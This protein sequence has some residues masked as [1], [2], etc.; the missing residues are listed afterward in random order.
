MNNKVLGIQ[1]Q[2][3]DLFVI[4]V[5]F[6]INVIFCWFVDYYFCLTRYSQRISIKQTHPSVGKNHPYLS[7]VLSPEKHIYFRKI[8]FS[9]TT[10]N[11]LTKSVCYLTLLSCPCVYNFLKRQSDFWQVEKQSTPNYWIEWLLGNSAHRTPRSWNMILVILYLLLKFVVPFLNHSWQY[12]VSNYRRLFI[13]ST[14]KRRI[15]LYPVN[16]FRYKVW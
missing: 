12:R 8:T 11:F 6:A 1:C 9:H 14:R 2:I 15:C 3:I 7:Q 16:E 5:L 10:F 4:G 13:Y